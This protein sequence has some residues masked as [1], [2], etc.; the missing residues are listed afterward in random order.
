MTDDFDALRQRQDQTE[1]RVIVLEDDA[2]IQKRAFADMDRDASDLKVQYGKQKQML[3]ALADTQ[4]DHTKRLMR[5]ETDVSE[6]KTKVTRLETDV[7]EVKTKVTRLE[8][9]VSEVKT[10]VTRLETDVSE[11]KT[12]LGVVHEGIDTVIDLLNKAS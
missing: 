10:K 6:V 1:G 7:S 8:T 5:L 2:R 9:D 12:K 3:Q 11:V 4:S